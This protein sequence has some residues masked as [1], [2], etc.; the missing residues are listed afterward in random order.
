MKNKDKKNLLTLIAILA[1]AFSIA[2]FFFPV[3]SF[4][5]YDYNEEYKTNWK[6]ENYIFFSR[7]IHYDSNDKVDSIISYPFYI[8]SSSK[9][10][11]N[12]N[13]DKDENFSLRSGKALPTLFVIIS[14]ISL[15]FMFFYFCYRSFRFCGKEKTRYFLF[16]AVIM[17]LFM[18][19][20]MIGTYMILSQTFQN[21]FLIRLNLSFY[22][23][24]ISI[25]LFLL[26][27]ILQN[28]YIDYEEDVPKTGQEQFEKFKKIE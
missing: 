6:K 8:E 3:Y 9:Y 24:I 5:T 28:R 21:I 26:A 27:Y 2:Q 25:F 10:Q 22:Y 16:T 19:F 13:L 18:S 20:F 7:F 11:Y 4:S 17:L 14:V 12:I 1:V 15:Y 23:M